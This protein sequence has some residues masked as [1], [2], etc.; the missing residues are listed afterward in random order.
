MRSGKVYGHMHSRAEE[1][2]VIHLLGSAFG[3]F[4]WAT[5]FLVL[6]IASAV[7][8]QLS[9]VAVLSPGGVFLTALACLTTI[10]AS[11]VIAHAFL[12]WRGKRCH[13]EQLFLTRIAVG[14]DA[15]AALAIMWQLI[16]LFTVPLCR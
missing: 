1:H 8:C 12:Q 7:A 5:H 10:A 14:Q 15:I 3:F 4:V 16:P 6:Y 2:G 13:T 11:V 9:A